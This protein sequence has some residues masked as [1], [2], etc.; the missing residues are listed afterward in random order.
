[1]ILWKGLYCRVSISRSC[2]VSSWSRAPVAFARTKMLHS[3][4]CRSMCSWRAAVKFSS[5]H[6]TNSASLTVIHC[7]GTVRCYTTAPAPLDDVMNVFDRKTKR[8][9]KNRTADMP[10]YNVYDYLKDEV[11]CVL[12][13]FRHKWLIE[14]NSRILCDVLKDLWG[15]TKHRTVRTPPKYMLGF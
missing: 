7:R 2:A 3:M 9:Q 13:Y 15:V 12:L 5:A 8:E 1:M 14:T 11:C 6:M 4:T 10:Q